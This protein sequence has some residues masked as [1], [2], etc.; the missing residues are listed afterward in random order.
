VIGFRQRSWRC[1]SLGKSR[2]SLGIFSIANPGWLPSLSAQPLLARQMPFQRFRHWYEI[3]IH[4]FGSIQMQ[5][6]MHAI[7]SVLT[8]AQALKIADAE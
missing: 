7:G 5:L 8:I 4:A 2:L 6:T 1:S 3:N